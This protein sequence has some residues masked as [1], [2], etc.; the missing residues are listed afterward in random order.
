MFHAGALVTGG[1]DNYVQL[2]NFETQAAR[3]GNCTMTLTEHTDFVS[4]IAMCPNP[5]TPYLLAS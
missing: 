4:S 3:K 5:A 2:W 1:V